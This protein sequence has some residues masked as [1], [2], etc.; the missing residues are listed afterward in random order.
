[1]GF[2]F[3]GLNLNS[4]IIIMYINKRRKDIIRSS[5]S[6]IFI[7]ISKIDI[8]TKNDYFDYYLY[9]YII[10]TTKTCSKFN[11]LKL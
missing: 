4:A 10:V 2:Y 5:N 3:K 8:I 6:N 9:L 7:F 1:M 11:I